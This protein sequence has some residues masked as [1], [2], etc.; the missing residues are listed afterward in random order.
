MSATNPARAHQRQPRLPQGRLRTVGGF[1]P[2]FQRVKDGIGSLED[3]EW[4][5]RLWKAGGRA[6]YRPELVAST[7]VP[8]DSPDPRL[9]PPLAFGPR[10]L[11][12]A[13]A[14]A[15]E[16]EKTARGASLGVPAHMYRS[17]LDA[18]AGLGICQPP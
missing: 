9:S 5:R 2:V 1:S 13:A 7:D 15:T 18:I 6:L 11:L 17:A 12:C 8:G 3:D 14:G 10:P 4:N 16:M